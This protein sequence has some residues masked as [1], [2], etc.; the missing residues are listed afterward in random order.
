MIANVFSNISK[1]DNISNIP[2]YC[3]L[4]LG[5]ID[6]IKIFTSSATSNTVATIASLFFNAILTFMTL[7][8]Y[9]YICK[10]I[11]SKAKEK[12]DDYLVNFGYKTWYIIFS[13]NILFIIFSPFFLN[14][15][16][17]LGILVIGI[18]ILGIIAIIRLLI[19][20]RKAHYR[21]Q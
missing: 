19:L 4:T 15:G 3:A 2:L 10:I 16:S 20:I 21:L 5:I 1:E 18:W 17:S 11:I 13:Y 8:I 6:I 9:Y 14:I 12:E 7:V